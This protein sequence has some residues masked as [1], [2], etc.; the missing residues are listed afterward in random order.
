[1]E[2]PLSKGDFQADWKIKR[3][4]CPLTLG[5]FAAC[6]QRSV[7]KLHPVA[8]S[9]NN[10]QAGI[11]ISGEIT[12]ITRTDST[13]QMN[14]QFPVMLSLA[15]AILTAIKTQTLKRS[16]QASHI[17]RERWS[18][19]SDRNGTKDFW[20]PTSGC[21]TTEISSWKHS[22]LSVLPLFFVDIF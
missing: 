3:E 9:S 16:Q 2:L 12:L 5:T 6:T 13:L 8:T 19:S 17:S 1:M 21:L 7:L 22:H 18:P 4:I 10:R 14:S 15:R 20:L 11:W